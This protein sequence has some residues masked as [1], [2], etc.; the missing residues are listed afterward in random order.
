MA[1][2]LRIEYARD[3]CGLGQETFACSF[4]GLGDDGNFVCLKCSELEGIIIRRRAERATTAM[5]DNCS[6]PPDFVLAKE[7]AN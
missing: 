7:T 3:V 2:R 1:N 4:L 5:G 6:G